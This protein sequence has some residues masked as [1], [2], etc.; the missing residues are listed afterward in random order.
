VAV[1]D[2][3]KRLLGPAHL[4]RKLSLVGLA[5]AILAVY[6]MFAT[7]SVDAN[8]RVEG[9]IERALVA[10]FDGFVRSAPRR[11]GDI[12]KEGDPIATLDDRDLWLQRSSWIA[13]RQQRRFEYDRALG[14]RDRAEANIAQA[15]IEKASAQVALLDEKLARSNIVAPFTGVIAEGDLSRAVGGPVHAG[16]TFPH[17]ASQRLPGHA[18]CRR[19]SACR[20]LRRSVRPIANNLVAGSAIPD[21][22]R[23]HNASGRGA[24]RPHGVSCGGDS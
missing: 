8:S 17:R 13:E 11:A 23:T 18:R 20:H 3:A 7:Y 2:Q 21:S 15:Q 6:G 22:R 14:S 10:P 16:D 24:G 9:R 1:Q 5:L 4:G 12:V 19:R